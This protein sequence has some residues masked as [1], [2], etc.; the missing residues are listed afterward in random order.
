MSTITMEY[1]K[2]RSYP[3]LLFRKIYPFPGS[4]QNIAVKR[5]VTQ[6]LCNK[7]RGY[8]VVV[9]ATPCQGQDYEHHYYCC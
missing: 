6:D 5:R 4:L 9:M 3:L 7:C 2:W 8:V 1:F